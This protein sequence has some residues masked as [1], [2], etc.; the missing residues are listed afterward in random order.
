MEQLERYRPIVDD[1]EAFFAACRRPLPRTVRV[2]SLKTDRQTVQSTLRSAGIETTP[3]EWHDR[4]LTVGDETPGATLPWYLGWIYGQEEVSA[5]PVTLLGPERGET[6]LDVAAAP[7][8][9]TTQIAEAMADT[10]RVIANDSNLGRIAPLRSNTERLGITN[11]AVTHS[12][13]RALSLAPFEVDAV[14]RTLVDVPCSGEGTIRKNPDAL[15]N[16]SVDRIEGIAGVQK[17]LL[18]RAISLTKPGGRIVYST[19]TF[20]PE[21]NEGVLDHVL[22]ETDVRICPQQLPVDST[23]GVTAW[24]GQSYDERVRRADRIYPHHNDTGGF[25]CA[26]LEVP[27]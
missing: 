8:S 5:L 18:K 6:V 15:A 9:K 16:W 27:A 19:C 10:G 11:T 17:G 3:V 26:T 25:F 24:Q 7:G 14:D 12:D 1:A 20:A 13:G 4:L 22:S 21:E 2:N 23:P